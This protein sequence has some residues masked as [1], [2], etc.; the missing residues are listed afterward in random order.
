MEEVTTTEKPNPN[1]LVSIIVITYNSAKYVLETLESAKAQT[2]ENIELI[3]TD[4]ASQDDTVEI[5][6]SWL[7][8]NKERF[9]RTELVTVNENSGIPANC[10]RGLY[11][12]TGEWI[13]LIAGDDVF[14]TN[15]ILSI[16]KHFNKS[17]RL[18]C[19][20]IFEFSKNGIENSIFIWPKFRFPNENKIQLK[21]QL[22]GSFIFAPSVMINRK[23]LLKVEG[24]NEEY[25]LFEDDPLWLKLLDSGVKFNYVED[26]KI[27]YRSHSDSISR[28][29]T[30]FFLRKNFY[31]DWLKFQ[32]TQVLRYSIQKKF[33]LVFLLVKLDIFIKNSILFCGNKRDNNI[34]KFLMFCLRCSNYLK[35]RYRIFLNK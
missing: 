18:Y 32:K 7:E 3:I 8:E 29:D 5:C 19:G 33:I 4:D 12:S 21:F 16:S 11:A 23:L 27:F 1:P 9:V 6:R 35:N 31:I 20:C 10:N 15:Y 24:F 25:K 30:I 17:N 13:K 22:L 2:Y 34:I 28:S 14:D 26:A